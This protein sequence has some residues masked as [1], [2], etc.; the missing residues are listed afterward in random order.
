MAACFLISLAARARAG[1]GGHQLFF[2]SILAVSWNHGRKAPAR[3][4]APSAPGGMIWPEAVPR[5]PELVTLPFEMTPW[6]LLD[7]DWPGLTWY[8]HLPSRPSPG[9]GSCAAGAP[10]SRSTSAIPCGP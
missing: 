3:P 1:P 7:G 8:G 2:A 5:Q 6:R 4:A 10:A 9:S